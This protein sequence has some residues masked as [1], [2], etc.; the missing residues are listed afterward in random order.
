MRRE[1]QDNIH[2]TEI[3]KETKRAMER[4]A[5][6]TNQRGGG[7]GGLTYFKKMVEIMGIN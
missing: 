2:Q 3:D 4:R 6:A 1:Y 5:R 7:G